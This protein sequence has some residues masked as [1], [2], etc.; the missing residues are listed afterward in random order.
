MC[1]WILFFLSLLVCS[2]V[3]H[4]GRQDMGGRSRQCLVLFF[5]SCVESVVALLNFLIVWRAKVCFDTTG[6]S[7]RRG[8]LSPSL[9][10]PFEL[11]TTYSFSFLIVSP[12]LSL[13]FFFH[14]ASVVLMLVAIFALFSLCSEFCLGLFPRR[15]REGEGETRNGKER[16]VYPSVTASV[17]LRRRR[18][19]VFVFIWLGS[20]VGRRR[21]SSVV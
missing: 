14:S 1:A 7:S 8:P 19:G 2:P 21:W 20:W 11:L 4:K 12:S 5:S 13:F 6:R 3:S 17:R 15:E 16:N 10:P 18:R 9:L